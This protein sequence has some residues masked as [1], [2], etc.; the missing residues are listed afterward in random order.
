MVATRKYSNSEKQK[1]SFLEFRVFFSL[2]FAQRFIRDKNGN[3]IVIYETFNVFD[4]FAE[5]MER[6]NR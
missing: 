5:K 2:C 3:G 4:L 6:K 1:N